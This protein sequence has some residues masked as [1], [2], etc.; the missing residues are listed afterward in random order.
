MEIDPIKFKIKI[1][2]KVN[3][4]CDKCEYSTRNKKDFTRH[5]NTKKHNGIKTI[6]KGYICDLCKREYKHKSGLS[7]HIKI[8]GHTKKEKENEIMAYSVLK[9]ENEELKKENE[10]L[11]KEV[12]NLK[13][14][15][16]TLTK[17][18]CD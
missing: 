7:R 6:N 3:Y 10:E 5:L 11:T 15:I 8:C 17:L 1:D 16:A 12:K 2:N 18:I 9:K 4:K 13:E 14:T